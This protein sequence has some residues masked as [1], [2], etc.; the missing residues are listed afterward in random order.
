[1]GIDEFVDGFASLSDKISIKHIAHINYH[2]KRLS[3]RTSRNI[4]RLR[5]SVEAMKSENNFLLSAMSKHFQTQ[6]QQLE[7]MRLWR[8]WVLEKDPG[9]ISNE[10]QESLINL[11]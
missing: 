4:Q 3:L 8:E 11:E 5:T 1:M 2:I 9:A 10:M 7:Y 6:Q